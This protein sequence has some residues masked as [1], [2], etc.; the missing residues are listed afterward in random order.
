MIQV[1][2]LVSDIDKLRNEPL[3]SQRLKDKARILLEQFKPNN[4]EEELLREQKNF[5]INEESIPTLER[6][7]YREVKSDILR[8]KIEDLPLEESDVDIIIANGGAGKSSVIWSLGDFIL[9]KTKYI[10]IYIAIRDFSSIDEI[11]K[12]VEDMFNGKNLKELSELE[13]MVF[14]FDG[15]SE[16]SYGVNQDSEIRKLLSFINSSKVILTSR[17]TSQTINARY[18]E[19]E[20][21]DSEQVNHYLKNYG[22][23]G[24]DI[25][26]SLFQVLSYPLMLILYI[27]SNAKL[28]SKAELFQE[29]FYRITYN[30]NS[31]TNLLK[32]LSIT[33]LEL[34]LRSKKSNW[35]TFESVF[36]E[37][38]KECTNESFNYQI[39]SLGIFNKRSGTIEPIHDLYWE[40]L[41]GCG[42]FFKWDEIK[43]DVVR[44]F[45]LRKNAYISLGTSLIK[46]PSESD[47]IKLI[48]YD[49]VLA[50]HFVENL[51]EL[52]SYSKL[53]CRFKSELITKLES[54]IESDIYRAIQAVFISRCETLLPYAL[55]K[56]DSL[57]QSGF[58]LNGLI[59]VIPDGF[60][61]ENKDFFIDHLNDSKSS[62]IVSSVIE[63]SNFSGWASWV[64]ELYLNGKISFDSAL[65][66]YFSSSDRLP[67]WLVD[68]L[69][70]FLID[71]KYYY[72]RHAAERGSNKEL[73]CWLYENIDVLLPEGKKDSSGFWDIN[74]T[75]ANCGDEK[76][77][78]KI[79]QDFY[80][81]SSTHQEYLSYCFD[82][83]D[84]KWIIS[85]KINLLYSD[86]SMHVKSKLFDILSVHFSDEELRVWACSDDIDISDLGWRSLARRKGLN[87]LDEILENLPES[88]AG[89]HKIPTLRALSE[90]KELPESV[91]QILIN[92]I[93]SPMQ[94]MA[95]ESFIAA[96]ANIKPNGILSILNWIQSNPFIFGSYHFEQFLNALKR[97]SKET[98]MKIMV[99]FDG[100][101]LRIEE[102][103]LFLQ[104]NN[105]DS[106][107]IP[108]W[109][110]LSLEYSENIFILEQVALSIANKIGSSR[111][112]NRIK[113]KSYNNSVFSVVANK[114]GLVDAYELHKDCLGVLSSAVI[115]EIFLEISERSTR[116]VTSFLYHLSMSSRRANQSYYLTIIETS[117]KL[118]LLNDENINYLCEILSPLSEEELINILSPYLQ[119]NENIVIKLTRLLEERIGRLLLNE[120]NEFLVY[121]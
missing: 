77:F 83:I 94:P 72:L 86:I 85:I 95:T 10:P 120:S 47:V 99:D 80:K 119:E 41:I 14:L 81:L 69:A 92:K 7:I 39:N 38:Y 43:N 42:I 90:I 36:K 20:L 44:N 110:R 23:E 8:V 17:P 28:K 2:G 102:Y 65:K 21:L 54:K 4:I 89:I 52:S 53:L 64:E 11:N 16:I 59:E 93:G 78:N 67:K 91:A 114:F 29:Y 96:M 71:R 22:L 105:N 5:N 37:R 35:A 58:R 66:V 27:A 56:I 111:D 34:E 32:S 61:W 73:A 45:R 98:G 57:Y 101:K 68:H 55:D 70:H 19:L 48:S 117:L 63:K 33:S 113:I 51:K 26:A 107:E 115:I 108:E 87:I 40:W 75:L 103:F 121:D 116:E 12:F 25:D 24:Y 31:T 100:N 97:W 30:F 6:V 46:P 50:S 18:W 60:I 109:I 9:R 15:V 84:S 13:N 112:L 3:S 104:L 62:Y 1:N 79:S 76:L 49:I 106:N 88:F 118:K 74:N 82:K